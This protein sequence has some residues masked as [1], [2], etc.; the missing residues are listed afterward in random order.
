MSSALNPFSL[1]IPDREALVKFFQRNYRMKAIYQDSGGVIWH[2]NKFTARHYDS[3]M[4]SFYGRFDLDEIL[5]GLTSEGLLKWELVWGCD[6]AGKGEMLGG[7]AFVCVCV[8]DICTLKKLLKLS[9]K[10]SK[11]LK[12]ERLL[13]TASELIKLKRG[14][15]LIA[16]LKLVS[17]KM[18]NTLYSKLNN[19]TELMRSVYAE[20][21]SEIC[22]LSE[23]LPENLPDRIVI[24]GDLFS[25]S[26]DTENE[27][28]V[29]LVP[30]VNGERIKAVSTAS[31]IA[32]WLY[33]K[34]V[35]TILR[36]FGQNLKTS[37]TEV[38]SL[39]LDL[40]SRYPGLDLE[41]IFKLHFANFL[42]LKEKALSL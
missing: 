29:R 21:I 4:L 33:I 17:P 38:E 28:K 2:S 25:F 39:V 7:I 9:V 20:L 24:D 19:Q 13:K 18:Y 15:E 22:S 6:E 10:D 23:E 31:I 26:R 27:M 1:Y 37:H 12:R 3:G 42:R 32:K 40:L 35:E 11:K 41:S 5:T 30:M 34:H 36:T 16:L 14:G 8:P